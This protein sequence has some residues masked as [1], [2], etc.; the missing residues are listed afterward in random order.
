MTG[1]ADGIGIDT[2]LGITHTQAAIVDE[3]SHVT[4]KL[5]LTSMLRYVTSRYRHRS[6]RI[7]FARHKCLRMKR[8][9]D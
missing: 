8:L 2:I 6:L 5:L 4:R 3:D 9:I 1:R 7:N